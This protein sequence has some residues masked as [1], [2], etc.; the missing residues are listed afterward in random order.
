MEGTIIKIL[1]M[2]TVKIQ[3]VSSYKVKRVGNKKT[4]VKLII[5]TFYRYRSA[6]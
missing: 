5:Q 3:V 4:T 6:L 2:E 1:R